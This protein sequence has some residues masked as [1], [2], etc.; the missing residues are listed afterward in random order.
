MDNGH[1]AL[2]WYVV[3]ES[4]GGIDAEEMLKKHGIHAN[5]DVENG[6]F[7]S[8]GSLSHTGIALGFAIANRNRKVFLIISDGSATE[9]S[10][11]ESLRIAKTLNLTNLEIHA[12]F[13]GYTATSEIDIDYWE[14]FMKGFGF[15]VIFHHTDNGLAELN[16]VSGHYAIL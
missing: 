3:L 4:L 11:A 5:R 13:N 14:Q 9:G 7:A 8:N 6:L 16:G 1:A 12:N 15:P 10:L 2:S